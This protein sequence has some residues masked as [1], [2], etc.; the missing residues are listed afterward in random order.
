M[1]VGPVH[2]SDGFENQNRTELPCRNPTQDALHA[3]AAMIPHVN[4]ATTRHDPPHVILREKARD[5]RR[6]DGTCFRRPRVLCGAG[7]MGQGAK[8]EPQIPE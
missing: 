6:Q 2:G 3:G 7:L 1:G 5:F 4:G 8:N